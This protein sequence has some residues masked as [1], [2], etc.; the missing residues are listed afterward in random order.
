M[1][2]LVL[3][4]LAAV[5]LLVTACQTEKAHIAIP[6]QDLLPL[7]EEEAPDDIV[8]TPGGI[9]YR[10]NVQS[11][12]EDNPLSRVESTEVE[13]D[14]INVRYRDH[15]ASKADATRNNIFIVSPTRNKIFIVMRDG[16]LW[17]GSLELYTTSIPPGIE[18]AQ[19]FGGVTPV[20]MT[21]VLI[22]E[23]SADA[24]P[25]Q[26]PLEIGLEIDGEDYGTVPCTIEVV[27]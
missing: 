18:F 8:A 5:L 17:E 2:K 27:E 14:G 13:L 20:T 16:E 21:M 12:G 25:G 24:E 22:I 26:Y 15:V 1:K 19:V 3:I 10:A 6:T 9:A 23:I 4:T 7:G 11:N